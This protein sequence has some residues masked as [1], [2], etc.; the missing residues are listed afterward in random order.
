MFKYMGFIF[1]D[2]GVELGSQNCG[3][4]L[5]SVLTTVGSGSDF[6]K[7]EREIHPLEQSFSKC[8]PRTTGGPQVPR[9]GPRRPKVNYCD[10][11]NIQLRTKRT[12]SLHEL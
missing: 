2:H 3:I 6:E 4:S 12:P 1:Y 7:V 10:I 8:G 5:V 11:S 9:S